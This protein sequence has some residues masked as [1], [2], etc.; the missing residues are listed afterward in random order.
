MSIKKVPNWMI[1]WRRNDLVPL[2]R[3]C[4]HRRSTW[5]TVALRY[6]GRS[7]ATAF[8]A[9]ST[10]TGRTTLPTRHTIRHSLS[11]RTRRL[12]LTWAQRSELYR[13]N[14]PTIAEHISVHA[15]L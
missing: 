5:Q 13:Q 9:P 4:R 6:R 8:S 14:L 12:E 1:F 2:L 7:S 15:V 10:P 3:W 11:P